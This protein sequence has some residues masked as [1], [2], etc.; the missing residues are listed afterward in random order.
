MTLRSG[1]GSAEGQSEVRTESVGS[2]EVGWESFY[3]RDCHFAR[4]LALHQAAL[5][6]KKA[7]SYLTRSLEE[8]RVERVANA[9]LCPCSLL[10]RVQV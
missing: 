3:G 2:C 7:L 8:G 1:S 9:G 5:V 4:A 10:T 6:R